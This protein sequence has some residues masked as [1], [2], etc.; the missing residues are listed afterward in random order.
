MKNKILI[1]ML[2]A[3]LCLSPAGCSYHPAPVGTEAAPTETV[4]ETT[5]LPPAETKPLP[6]PEPGPEAFVPVQKYMPGIHVDLRYATAD[7]FTAQQIYGFRDVYLRYGT[8]KKLQRV[9]AELEPMGLSLKIWD[10][11]RPVLAQ[12]RLWEVC[13]DPTYVANPETGFSSHSRGNTID[14]TLVDR[15]GNELE[16]P[17]AFDDFSSLADR[18]YSDCSET[19]AQNAVLLQNIMEKQGFTGYF[20]EWW[21]FTDKDAYDVERVFLPV[22]QPDAYIGGDEMI[23]LRIRPDADSEAVGSISSGEAYYLLAW[24]E[25]YVMV[26][27]RDIWGYISVEDLPAIE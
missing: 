25:D 19:A 4:P 7:N 2:T 11:F 22:Y 20:G 21:H 24:Y 26:E 23:S 17:T 1:L 6:L 14:L 12:Y 16:M 18:D 27:Y 8:V 5:V 9:Q 15:A 13:P 10:G 3:C